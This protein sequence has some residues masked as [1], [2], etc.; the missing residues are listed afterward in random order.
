VTVSVLALDRRS[1]AV[2]VAVA[3]RALAV[4][5]R[6]PFLRQSVGVVVI[7]AFAPMTWGPLVLDQ[8]SVGGT[9]DDVLGRLAGLPE[10]QRAQV[11]VVDVRGVA[12]G[13]TGPAVEPEADI[14]Y[15]DACCSA[16]NLME[17]PGVTQAVISAYESS[18]KATFA[19]RL[20]DGLLAADALGGDIRGRQSAAVGVSTPEGH[21]D[22]A[23]DLRVDDNQRPT[24]ELGRLLR[25]HRA[26]GLVAS[27]MVDGFYTNIEPLTEAVLLAPD[28]L[29]VVSALTL[30]LARA[31]RVVEASTHARH[32]LQLEPRTPQRVQR[33]IQSGNLSPEVGHSLLAQLEAS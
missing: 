9:P 13:F 15:G 22:A 10:S 1:G 25:L 33:L 16:A 24:Q 26:D 14:T 18:R 4:G 30:A 7:Q 31:G 8:L 28:D 12:A 6:V 21:P 17:R 32:L 3:S 23:V 27:S 5:S 29:G 11:A 20:F 19:E 2:G